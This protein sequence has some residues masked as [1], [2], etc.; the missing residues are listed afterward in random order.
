MRTIGTLAF[1][2]ICEL[3]GKTSRYADAIR[4]RADRAEYWAAMHRDTGRTDVAD[5][6]EWFG[7]ADLPRM[8]H[9]LA[10]PTT[11]T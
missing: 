11:P 4:R 7:P 2:A 10:E 9:Q 8:A 5:L 3:A 1:V 6:S